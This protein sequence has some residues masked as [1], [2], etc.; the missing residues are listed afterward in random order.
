[1][2]LTRI[3]PVDIQP[4]IENEEQR[5]P[6]SRA[7]QPKA[8]SLA[9]LQESPTATVFHNGE[10][11]TSSVQLGLLIPTN[12]NC[13]QGHEINWQG[14]QHVICADLSSYLPGVSGEPWP[15]LQPF[16]IISPGFE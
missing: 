3:F 12:E 8:E 6:V 5:H 9:T 1:M 14:G 10:A 11:L 13:A 15:S 7:N 4:G 2:Q 16:P